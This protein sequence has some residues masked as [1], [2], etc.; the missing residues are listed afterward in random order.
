M[1]ETEAASF[2]APAP[3]TPIVPLERILLPAKHDGRLGFNRAPP[4]TIRVLRAETDLE[5]VLSWL[6]E[7]ADSEHTRRSARKEAER[8]MLW[9]IVM[10]DKALSALDRQDLLEY[11]K[12]LVDPQPAAWW[13][14]P[15]RPRTDPTWRPFEGPLSPASRRQ[16][17]VILNG[18]FEYL[19]EEGYLI[20]N[21][22]PRKQ[23]GR[24]TRSEK[25]RGP[26]RHLPREAWE[27]ALRILEEL[28]AVTRH[29][30]LRKA[31]LKFL[32]MSTYIF[33][34][35][36][37]EIAG[38]HAGSLIKTGSRWEW[39]VRGKGSKVAD[40]PVPDEFIMLFKDYR[41]FQG[42]SPL[43]SPGE[44]TYLIPNLI[45]EWKG[46]A[47]TK[48]AG[49]KPGRVY[50]IVTA[51][52]RTHV[53]RAAALAKRE[54]AP[55]FSQ[56][57]TH[58]LRHTRITHLVEDDVPLQHV[59]VVSRHS[60]LDTVMLYNH[61][62]KARVH[63][64]VS[65]AASG[66]VPRFGVASPDSAEN[67]RRP[68]GEPRSSEA[69]AVYELRI[70]LRHVTPQVWRLFRVP[71]GITLA[72]LHD[73]IQLVMGWDNSHLY[74]FTL[75]NLLSPNSRLVDV[76]TP[77][78]RLMYRYD[79]GDYWEH[80]VTVEKEVT[81]DYGPMP[82]CIAGKYAC[83]PEDCG[84]PSGYIDVRKTLQ[85]RDGPK[86]RELVDWLGGKFDPK[87]FSLDEINAALQDWH[88]EQ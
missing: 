40:V 66:R 32:L 36:V 1:T 31:R 86:R 34:A 47:K 51:F 14:G 87:R 45:G 27:F 83:P 16:S 59:Q 84:G 42:L 13:C 39:H 43:P 61:E 52:F 50:R 37:S 54:D 85:G 88:K 68:K 4:G 46:D 33:G 76:A 8:L 30:Q 20:S 78:E 49:I 64:S 73:V 44:E 25:W 82:R 11:Q 65:S 62:S 28:P 81:D 79:M 48:A 35:R 63:Q 15:R 24:L 74:E 19:A 56:V 67:A 77:G 5:A 7:Y 60:S 70:A 6:D 80:V 22:M 38:H 21:P 53:A 72:H 26:E 55:L 3:A 58:W 17:L 57:T 18:L 41:T 29:Q 10:R 9:A 69:G 12:F 2:P 23:R 75:D 71:S